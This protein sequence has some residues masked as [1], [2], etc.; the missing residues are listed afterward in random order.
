M[1]LV[2]PHLCTTSLAATRPSSQACKRRIRQ[3]LRFSDV[4][5]RDIC[6]T[7]YGSNSHSPYASTREPTSFDSSSR[8]LS[9]AEVGQRFHFRLRTC[10]PPIKSVPSGAGTG[11]AEIS[12][13]AVRCRPRTVRILPRHLCAQHKVTVIP[14]A[15][16]VVRRTRGRQSGWRFVS[17]PLDCHFVVISVR[18][19]IQCSITTDFGT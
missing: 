14:C 5:H 8:E 16:A 1:S 7:P 2:L 15:C 4:P 11:T 13:P 10:T 9:P 18:T 19:A 6:S 12:C 3:A 17:S